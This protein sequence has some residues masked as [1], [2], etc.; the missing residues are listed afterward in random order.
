MKFSNRLPQILVQVFIKSMSGVLKKFNFEFEGNNIQVFVLEKDGKKKIY[1]AGNDVAKALGY[2]DP[3]GAV[4]THCPN[5]IDCQ[6]FL[7]RM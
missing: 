1:F 4:R 2:K 3:E 7:K 5:A 6:T